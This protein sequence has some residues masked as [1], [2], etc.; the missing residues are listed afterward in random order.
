MSWHYQ[1]RHRVDTGEHL[2]DIV[3]MYENPTGWTKD[4]SAPCGETKQELLDA[5]ARMFNDAIKYPVLED[6]EP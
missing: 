1:I 6:V 3:E 4:S 2:Y 5:L